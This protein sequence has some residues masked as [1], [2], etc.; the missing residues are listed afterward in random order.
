MIPLAIY[1]F[2]KDPK[3]VFNFSSMLTMEVDDI[4]KQTT[5]RTPKV[6]SSV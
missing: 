2:N 4:Y 5:S 3:D 6:D 1:F